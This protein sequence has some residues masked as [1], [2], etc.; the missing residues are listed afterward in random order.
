MNLRNLGNS[1]L[2][3][4]EECWWSLANP[5]INRMWPYYSYIRGKITGYKAYVEILDCV[6]Y[7]SDDA[8][9]YDVRSVENMR[10]PYNYP[11]FVV[12][13]RRTKKR[14]YPHFLDDGY[15]WIG[16]EEDTWFPTEEELADIKAKLSVV[17]PWHT[18]NGKPLSAFQQLKYDQNEYMFEDE[19]P[20]GT[21]FADPKTDEL[22]NGKEFYIP[23]GSPMPDWKV[24]TKPKRFNFK[25]NNKKEVT[26]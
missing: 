11:Y 19:V 1:I 14:F 23:I 15:E 24:P 13:N 17:Q 12:V 9:V 16:S 18:D 22:L 2:D 7:I 10:W 26:K 21:D 5:V 4:I 8:L 20:E 25:L 3:W 6:L